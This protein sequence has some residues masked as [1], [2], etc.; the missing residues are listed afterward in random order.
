[1]PDKE[2]EHTDI[3]FRPV[4]GSA[5]EQ[6]NFVELSTSHLPSRTDASTLGQCVPRMRVLSDT[7]GMLIPVIAEEEGDIIPEWLREI[8][9]WA[10]RH[11]YTHIL[12][13]SE[14]AVVHDLP[15]YAWE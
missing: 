13:D 4:D 11:E 8:I 9:E 5:L 3:S 1:M 2:A 15:V 7:F 6:H 14:G 10:D 12:F